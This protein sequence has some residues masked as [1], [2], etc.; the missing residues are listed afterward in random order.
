MQLPL[1]QPCFSGTLLLLAVSNLIL[2]APVTSSRIP[3]MAIEV[4]YQRLAQI[5]HFTHDYAS[6]LCTDYDMMFGT[7][8]TQDPLLVP[9]HTASII[10][11]EK[12]EQVHQTNSE[13]LMKM[14][15]SILQAWEEPLKH[16]V[17][18][19]ATLPGMSDDMLSRAKE[20]EERIHKLLE[21]LK[22]L[23]SKAYPGDVESDYISWYGWSD[24]QSFYEGTHCYVGILYRCLRR[25]THMVD[26]FVKVLKCRD[27]HSNN[28]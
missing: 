15:I 17:Y 27:V 5:S 4:I 26:N 3:Q 21:G 13:D 8:C 20:L 12:S 16:M 1:T 14:S 22:I 6:K 25:D 11:P 2:W 23:L 7:T 9:C 24:L 19:M 10:T 28:C 18:A